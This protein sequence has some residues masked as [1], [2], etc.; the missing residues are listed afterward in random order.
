MLFPSQRGHVLCWLLP[1]PSG[2]WMNMWLCTWRV[3]PGLR[4]LGFGHVSA[5]PLPCWVSVERLLPLAVSVPPPVGDCCGSG[6]TQQRFVGPC[7]GTSATWLFP[8]SL[9]LEMSSVLGAAA[10]SFGKIFLVVSSFFLPP[11][12]FSGVWICFLPLV[13]WN[14]QSRAWFQS[15]RRSLRNEHQ[16]RDSQ[17]NLW[18]RM[19][20]PILRQQGS[21][22]FPDYFQG[23]LQ[24][25]FDYVLCD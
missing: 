7:A 5:L 17:E 14:M 3:G 13:D 11:L 24:C 21:L 10:A 8:G 1:L 6:K 9:A 15:G 20:K 19:T 22:A 23:F 2:T 18:C 25:T 16:V 4:D 12:L